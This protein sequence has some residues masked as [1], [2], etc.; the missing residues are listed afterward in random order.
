MIVPKKLLG[1][2]RCVKYQEGTYCTKTQE[3]SM[4]KR[5]GE[6]VV[7]TT[8]LPKTPLVNQEYM[9]GSTEDATHACT[10]V[11]MQRYR[12]AEGMVGRHS[13][14]TTCK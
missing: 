11:R 12:C 4:C 5:E 2:V 7:G 10:L 8:V 1:T 9:T 3:D 14:R 6:P 13:P